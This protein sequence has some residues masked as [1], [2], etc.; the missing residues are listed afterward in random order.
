MNL[1]FAIPNILAG[2][3]ISALGWDL[4]NLRTWVCII[5]VAIVN[6]AFYA[7]RTE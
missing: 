4:T 2:L 1:V 5:P 7:A 6:A 3:L